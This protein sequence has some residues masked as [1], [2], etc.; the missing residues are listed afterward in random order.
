MTSRYT[1]WLGQLG[2]ELAGMFCPT[3]FK[4]PPYNAGQLG[5]YHYIWYKATWYTALALMIWG[6]EKIIKDVFR[7]WYVLVK[8]WFYSANI[9]GIVDDSFL[10]VNRSIVIYLCNE[11]VTHKF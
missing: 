1:S 7:C 6:R 3:L 8:E 2:P 11:E 4:R 5:S 9:G 10:K